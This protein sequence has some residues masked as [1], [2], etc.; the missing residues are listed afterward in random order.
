MDSYL[1]CRDPRHMNIWAEQCVLKICLH[2]GEL[3]ERQT[4]GSDVG[5]LEEKDY[6]DGSTFNVIH[7]I[8]LRET[9]SD[10]YLRELVETRSR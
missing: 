5:I 6:T 7:R 9:R 10:F 3:S 2:L 4:L 8:N 1:H